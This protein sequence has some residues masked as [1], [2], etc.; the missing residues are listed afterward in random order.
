MEFFDLL[1]RFFLLANPGSPIR[2][3]IHVAVKL[4][5]CNNDMYKSLETVGI[6]VR[7]NNV[8]SVIGSKQDT[9]SR[10]SV[11]VST[12]QLF[13]LSKKKKKVTEK[14]LRQQTRINYFK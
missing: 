1:I 14:S 4:L 6:W 11:P 7:I 12:L 9:G 13:E 5:M 3:F 2:H 10:H 8:V